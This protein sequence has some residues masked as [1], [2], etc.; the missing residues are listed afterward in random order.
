MSQSSFIPGKDGKIYFSTTTDETLANLSDTIDQAGDVEVDLG[1]SGGTTILTRANGGWEQNIPGAKTLSISF[2]YTL[3]PAG[4]LV[5]TALRT[6]YLNEAELTVAV[7]DRDKATS[8]SHGPRCNVT[9]ENFPISQPA[10]GPQTVNVELKI[11]KFLAW[12]TVA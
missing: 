10:S 1:R 7:M 2:P 9:V 12:E 8:G 4:D 11:S 6:A 3:L 5:A